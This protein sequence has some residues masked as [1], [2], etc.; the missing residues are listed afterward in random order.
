MTVASGR[1]FRVLVS[2]SAT[3]PPC[4]ETRVAKSPAAVAGSSV[5]TVADPVVMTSAED[6]TVSPAAP[7][8]AGSWATSAS[9]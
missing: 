1:S 3:R 2:V 7:A 4:S 6:V 8:L 5:R 9:P